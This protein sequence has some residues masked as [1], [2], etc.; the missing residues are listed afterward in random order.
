MKAITCTN[1]MVGRLIKKKKIENW[2]FCNFLY[3]TIAMYFTSFEST[4]GYITICGDG[5]NGSELQRSGVSSRFVCITLMRVLA[6][7]LHIEQARRKLLVR[8]SAHAQRSYAAYT[9]LRAMHSR[10]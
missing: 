6:P 7:S 1:F 8:P 5:Q 2:R 9:P 3:V 10:A 4:V